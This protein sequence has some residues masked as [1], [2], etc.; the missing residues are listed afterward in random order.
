MVSGNFEKL[1]VALAV[2]RTTGKYSVGTGVPVAP[3][4]VLTARHVV[5]PDNA[6]DT[7]V[8]VRFWHATEP[9]YR[10]DPDQDRSGYL[11]AIGQPDKGPDAARGVVWSSAELDAAL[12]AVS[13]PASVPIAYLSRIEPYNNADWLSEGFPH[14]AWEDETPTPRRLSGKSHSRIPNTARYQVDAHIAM[15]GAQAGRPIQ[16]GWSGAS[17]ASLFVNGQ[18][19]GI[20]LA[21][22]PS[23]DARVLEAVSVQDMLKVPEFRDALGHTET[24]ENSYKN[25]LAAAMTEIGP[26]AKAHL[27]TAVG[28]AEDSP[29]QEIAAALANQPMA[30]GI[31]LLSGLTEGASPLDASI[32]HLIAICYASYRS[33]PPDL[34]AL[35]DAAFDPSSGFDDCAAGS[36]MG[37]EFLMAAA[38]N[39]LPE[40]QPAGPRASALPPGTHALPPLPETGCDP[41]GVHVSKDL[42][43]RLGADLLD[44]DKWLEDSMGQV[45]D[46]PI[47]SKERVK[48]RREILQAELLYRAQ[49]EDAEPSY[50]F[51]EADPGPS[52]AA[53]REALQSRLQAIRKDYPEIGMVAIKPDLAPEE[54]RRFRPLLAL[55]PKEVEP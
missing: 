1:T 42:E 43:A 38:E 22:L 46:F 28:V 32:V 39:R 9:E 20:L 34:Q 23:G 35:R 36:R 14:G 5:V 47:D 33:A 11:D 24:P 51:A 53:E 27:A 19:M 40:F 25:E 21:R 54:F 29:D 55:L 4:L 15:A 16:D 37:A 6:A 52:R 18:I 10:H 31:K 49:S 50:Y 41:T 17:G 26:L 7:P 2:E 44:L 8:R 30:Q 45:C 3:G 48:I 12:V 13:H